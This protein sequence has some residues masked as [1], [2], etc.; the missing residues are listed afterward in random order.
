MLWVEAKGVFLDDANFQSFSVLVVLVR[1]LMKHSLENPTR[2]L[3]TSSGLKRAKPVNAL[4][5]RCAAHSTEVP[6]FV[7]RVWGQGTM[8]KGEFQLQGDGESW[9]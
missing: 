3:T 8:S 1:D 6:I 5:V 7:G 2:N 9:G 4:P